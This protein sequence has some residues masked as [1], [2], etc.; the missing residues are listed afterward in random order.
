MEQGDESQ[1]PDGGSTSVAPFDALFGDG[2]EDHD[3]LRQ[4]R[5]SFDAWLAHVVQQ[6]FPEDGGAARAGGVIA[7]R[8]VVVADDA[9]PRVAAW[10][11]QVLAQSGG[12]ID[13]AA[14]SEKDAGGG[15][16]IDE[17][18]QGFALLLMNF[19]PTANVDGPYSTFT[20]TELVVA[21]AGVLSNDFDWDGPSPLTAVLYSQ[22]SHGIV[23]L[24]SNGSF[25]Y[26]PATDYFGADTF[27]Y[28]A[29]DGAAFSTVASATLNVLRP[30]IDVD[31]DSNNNNN[32]IEP[33]PEGQGEGG[34]EM[35]NPGN[36]IQYNWDDDNGNSSQD[37]LDGG[38]FVDG[39]GAPV[40]DDEL[41]RATLALNMAPNGFTVHIVKHGA[42]IKLWK[43]TDKQALPLTYTI[44]TDTVPTEFWI[45]GCDY[46]QATV[47]TVLKNQA[48][49][50]VHRDEIKVTVASVDLIAF[51]PQTE[52]PGYGNPF[53]FTAV[54]DNHE[55]E[56]GIGIRKNGDDDDNDRK[57]DLD[58]TDVSI[59]GEND[60]IE[61]ELVVKAG[62]AQGIQKVLRRSDA[63]INVFGGSDKS[64]PILDSNDQ[65]QLVTG[66]LNGNQGWVEWVGAVPGETVL[67]LEVQDARNGNTAF[68]TAIVFRPFT[69]VVIAFGGNGNEP[70]AASDGAFDIAEYLYAN[71]YDVH[72]YNEET[73]D[74]AERIPY[75]E[76]KSAVEERSVG[77]VAIYG[78]SQGGGATF[79]LAE[80]LRDDPLAS[81]WV[82]V[83]TAY[84]DGIRHN[85]IFSQDEE[86]PNTQYHVNYFQTHA[87]LAGV[88]IPEAEVNVNVNETAWGEDLG[89][90]DIDNDP[91][92]QERIENG[93]GG[94][95]DP[96]HDGLTDKTPR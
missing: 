66:P 42:Q 74:A 53:P 14:P 24:N 50:V 60:L 6:L 40:V 45:E 91:T 38:P 94:P 87:G 78:F 82:L 73:V 56:P 23:S 46:G 13:A 55:L 29:Y 92:V 34:I 54:P 89:H 80:Q 67:R 90:S 71:G 27:Q 12:A 49:A 22:A 70:L 47:E 7:L 3:W 28:R 4:A 86:P 8:A 88:S 62:G 21:A 51:R 11:F 9:G 25:N 2:V 61:I 63:E 44:G 36:I 68:Y 32:I 48:G 95:V 59:A 26:M 69:S 1:G 57:A 72:A 16:T 77:A 37:R 18:G 83:F 35:D 84:I 17:G 5:Q 33:A 58:K 81:P 30:T 64:D 41:E 75:N 31:T 96:Q 43:T 19:P 79:V 52:G 15:E 39:N 85:G 93:Y 10:G 65:A 20:N 76:V